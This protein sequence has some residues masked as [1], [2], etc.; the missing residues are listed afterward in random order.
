[1]ERRRA[2]P[3]HDVA[4][5]AIEDAILDD[6]LGKA[7]YDHD[8]ALTEIDALRFLAGRS[9]I[10]PY[11]EDVQFA[12]GAP[13]FAMGDTG[14]ALFFLVRVASCWRCRRAPRRRRPWSRGR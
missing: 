2:P 6:E 3:T 7:R 9:A 8:A 11:L 4:L 1:V 14:D 5:A 13:L 10:V 12:D